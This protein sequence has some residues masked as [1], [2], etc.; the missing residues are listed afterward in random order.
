MQKLMF[1]EASKYQQRFVDQVDI[2]RHRS[3]G[4]ADI[5]NHLLRGKELNSEAKKLMRR[6]ENGEE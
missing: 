5:L 6:I 3:A 2:I 4:Y 1:R